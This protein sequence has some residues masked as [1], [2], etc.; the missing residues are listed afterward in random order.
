MTRVK[1]LKTPRGQR[2][3]TPGDDERSR[4]QRDRVLY[5]S[6]PA[7]LIYQA[8]G[9]SKSW[10]EKGPGSPKLKMW[11]ELAAPE[12]V[13]W[14]AAFNSYREETGLGSHVILPVPAA[15]TALI[16]VS[17]GT[18]YVS[19]VVP[20]TSLRDVTTIGPHLR[21]VVLPGLTEALDKIYADNTT[22]QAEPEEYPI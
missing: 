22:G 18:A 3:E 4:S 9:H 19:H 14:R 2:S 21:D 16:T 11:H 15:Q 12:R 13:A 6:D 5:A 7:A 1:R 17:R 10:R 20:L 8:Y